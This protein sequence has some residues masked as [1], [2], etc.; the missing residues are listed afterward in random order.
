VPPTVTELDLDAAGINCVVWATGYRLDFAWVD[1]PVFDEW[2][3]P[4]HRRG[5]TVQPGLYAIGLPWL[6]T[7]SSAGFNGV[8]A[9][10]A[11][12]VDHIAARSRGL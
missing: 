1:L 11:H 4:R 10:A 3:Y 8:G 5:V 2:D 12:I 6:H 9:D 7:E